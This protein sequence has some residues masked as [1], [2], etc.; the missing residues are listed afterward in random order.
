MEGQDPYTPKNYDSKFRGPITLRS[1]LA[2]SR[3]I[4]AV[5]VINALGVNKVRENGIK[6]GITTWA[7][8]NRFGPSLT[9]GG[10]EVTLLDLAQAYTAFPNMGAKIPLNPVLDI[11]DYKNKVYY[12]ASC[13]DFSIEKC[14]TEQVLDPRVAFQIIDILRDNNARTPAF[15][16]NSMLVIRDHPEVAVKTG[17]SNDL[18]DNLTVG[19]NQDYLTAVW[20][21]NN[22]NSPMSRVASGVTGASPIWNKI[23]SALLADKQSKDWQ[24]PEGLIQKQCLGRDEWFLQENISECR[25]PSPTPG[26]ADNHITP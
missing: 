20:V 18:R 10:G 26:S 24:P 22:D 9:L 17:T 23:M 25:F 11:K 5:R 16:S 2:E 15:G 6:M 4:P 21:G 1:A 3:N 12:H 8:K 13:T 7:D 19:F 14:P